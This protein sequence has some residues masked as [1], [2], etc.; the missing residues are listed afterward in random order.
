MLTLVLGVARCKPSTSATQRQSR[1]C[2]ISIGTGVR[3]INLLT[4]A[5]SRRAFSDQI[6][7]ALIDAIL[8]L[9]FIKRTMCQMS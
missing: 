8:R 5:S 7:S 6:R 1:H 2:A 9:T 3:Q 4:L